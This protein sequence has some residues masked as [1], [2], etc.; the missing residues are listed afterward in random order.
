M[1]EKEKR[2]LIIPEDVERKTQKK[3]R[4]DPQDIILKTKY[5]MRKKRKINRC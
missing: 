2:K 1:D 4:E 5:L 3:R